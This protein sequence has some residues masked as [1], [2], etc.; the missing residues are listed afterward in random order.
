MLDNTESEQRAH[1]PS[2]DRPR[3]VQAIVIGAGQAGLAAGRCLAEAGVDFLI[4]EAAD[5][6][7]DVWRHRWDSLRLFTAAEFAGLPGLPFPGDPNAF[8]SKD[9]LA[10][11]LEAYAVHFRLP[12]R[13]NTVVDRMERIGDR[14]LI[15]ASNAT[16]EAEHVVVASGS[17]Q[18]TDA[19]QWAGSLGAAIV[20]IRAS[21]YKNPG[22]LAPG[23]VLVVGAGNSGAELAL[24]AAATGHRVWLS[25]RDVGQVPR[26]LRFANGRPFWFLATRIFTMKTPIGRKIARALRAGHSG[27][28]VRIRSKDIPDAGIIRVPRVTGSRDG[29]PELAD[30]RLL[31]V[32]TIVWCTGIGPDYGW[33]RLPVFEADGY[34]RHDRG[35]VVTEPGL[36]FVGLTFQYSLS[37][38]TL[39]GVGRDAA[40]VARWIAEHLDRSRS[41]SHVNVAHAPA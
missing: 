1:R 3:R 8:P 20:Q 38:G 14:Y 13:F 28:L 12:I 23:G 22:Q 17:H 41:T 26:F 33:I 10:D 34:P 21:D 25:G 2:E 24:E 39:V 27:P 16:F 37:S 6:V 9:E 32:S 4:L 35:R 7:G 40:L 18:K 11:Y 30:G 15:T 29:Q 5:R 31:D 36:Y 19:P